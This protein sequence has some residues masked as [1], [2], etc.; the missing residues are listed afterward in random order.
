MLVEGG[1]RRGTPRNLLP[2]ENKGR[3]RARAWLVLGAPRRPP[4]PGDFLLC[5]L[6]PSAVHTGTLEAQ[7]PTRPWLK[8]HRTVRYDITCFRAGE[9]DQYSRLL[10]FLKVA[11]V[12]G[13]VKACSW[14]NETVEMIYTNDFTDEE[15][16]S[17]L[18]LGLIPEESASTLE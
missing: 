10:L 16:P 5:P 3:C 2:R 6:E 18:G 14:Q 8:S 11:S 7:L 1:F 13:S 17:S 4:G 12:R 15:K 9:R